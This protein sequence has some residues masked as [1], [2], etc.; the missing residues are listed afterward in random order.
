MSF[1][2]FRNSIESSENNLISIMKTVHIKIDSEETK[3]KAKIEVSFLVSQTNIQK[4]IFKWFQ[5]TRGSRKS[6][7]VLQQAVDDKENL[8]GRPALKDT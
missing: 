4:L 7:K 3:V 1:D 5:E 8:A 6:L 2:I